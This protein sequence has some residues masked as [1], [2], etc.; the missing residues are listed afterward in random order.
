MTNLTEDEY[1]CLMILNEGGPLIYMKDTRWASSL[2]S[3]EAK[4]YAVADANLSRDT[5]N[6]NFKIT[7]MGKRALADHEKGHDEALAALVN[8]T[9]DISRLKATMREKM[10]QAGTLLVEAA[11]LG[12]KATG[13]S[14]AHAMQQILDEIASRAKQDLL[15]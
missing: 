10:M 6:K 14:E 3:L 12:A 15:K 5:G 11:R 1:T 4:E 9:A 7:A 8:R 13:Q 2:V